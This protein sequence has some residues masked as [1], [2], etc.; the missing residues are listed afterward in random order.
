M[1]KKLIC[2]LPILIIINLVISSKTYAGVSCEYE[3]TYIYDCP[4]C[5]MLMNW[6][7]S[8][9]PSSG[10]FGSDQAH[11]NAA[12]PEACRER[13]D[14]LAAESLN[15]V[16]LGGG[17][18]DLVNVSSGGTSCG[19]VTTKPRSGNNSISGSGSISR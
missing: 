8:A 3:Y 19:I 5:T 7:H 12:S 6:S 9:G 10:G 11:V 4:N 13:A 18:C 16:G 2:L 14:E 15:K 17:Y 1:F